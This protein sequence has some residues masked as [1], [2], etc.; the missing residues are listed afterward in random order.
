MRSFAKIKLSRKTHSMPEV[1]APLL[2]YTKIENQR[3]LRPKFRPLALLNSYA[4]KK[5]SRTKMA[6]TLMA[7]LPGLARNII[8]VPTGNLKHNPPWMA[9]TTLA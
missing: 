9:G 2:A 8:M 7:H 3:M 4:F 5:C 1:N 6:R